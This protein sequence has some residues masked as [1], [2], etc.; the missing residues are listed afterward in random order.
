M[1]DVHDSL[2]LSRARALARLEKVEDSLRAFD[3]LLA[4]LQRRIVDGR[5]DL[6][7]PLVLARVERLQALELFGCD[8]EAIAERAAFVAEIEDLRSAHPEL[9]FTLAMERDLLARALLREGRSDEALLHAHA[10]V[11]AFRAYRAEKG[12]SAEVHLRIAELSLANA[13]AALGRNEEAVAL[14]AEIVEALRAL[15]GESRCD[16]AWL[17]SALK[18][19]A[20]LQR[21]L[22]ED[23][24]HP[25]LLL[26]SEKMGA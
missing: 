2:R 1:A 7:L 13:L 22:A 25:L 23:A 8:V 17:E 15:V 20:E 9:S 14:V 18:L 16:A 4:D 10:S 6:V 21:D 12:S 19:R 3:E 24:R 26:A 5:E 11:D